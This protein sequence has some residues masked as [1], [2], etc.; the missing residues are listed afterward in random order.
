MTNTQ[1]WTRWICWGVVFLVAQYWVIRWAVVAA[2]RSW[3]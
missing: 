1:Y 2:L 3:R